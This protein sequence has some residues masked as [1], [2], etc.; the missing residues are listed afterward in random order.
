MEFCTIQS[1]DEKTIGELLQVYPESNAEFLKKDYIGRHDSEETAWAAFV[2]DYADFIAE[3]ISQDDRYIFALREGGVIVAALRIIHISQDNWYLE[4]LGTVPE[5]RGLGCAIR[6]AVCG[7]SVRT[8]SSASCA[9][10]TLLRAR[11]TRPAAL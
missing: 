10:I 11:H 2:Q 6:C 4:A 5:R 3:F 1:S 9:R 8:A 7:R